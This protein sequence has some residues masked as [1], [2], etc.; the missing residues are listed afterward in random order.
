MGQGHGFSS[1]HKMIIAP[2]TVRWMS[3][4]QQSGHCPEALGEQRPPASLQTVPLP[5][6][7]PGTTTQ[8]SV[9]RGALGGELPVGSKNR[10]RVICALG[11]K[12][13]GAVVGE[14]LESHSK[15]LRT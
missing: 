9:L 2:G 6:Q 11:P 1:T 8:R 14:A 12:E 3:G 10:G 4:D 13:M 5:G 7:T 15:E